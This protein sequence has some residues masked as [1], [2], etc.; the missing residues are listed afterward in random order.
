MAIKTKKSYLELI[1]SYHKNQE[2]FVFFVGSGLSQPL[3]PSWCKL[4]EELLEIAKESNP[5]YDE[6]ELKQYIK[7]GVHYLDIAEACVRVINPNKYRDLMEK[8]FDKEFTLDDISE[9][10]KA[11]MALSPKLI[12]T[13]NYDR[14]P[15]I[16]GKGRYRSCTNKN[17][18]EAMR[19]I[20]DGKNVVFKMHGD[21]TDQSSIVL[22][23]S[24]YQK[25][26]HNNPSTQ[27]LFKNLLSTKVL[28]FIGFSL[29]DPHIETIL[30]NIKSINKDIPLSHYVLLN[31]ESTFK[32]TTFENKY[33]V[34]IISY[35]PEN[36][37]HPE[38]ADLLR[39]LNHEIGEIPEATEKKIISEISDINILLKY[40]DKAISDTIVGS[41]VSIFYENNDIYLSFTP[42]GETMSEI[43][44]E[45]LSIIRL[46]NFECKLF[47][48]LIILAIAKTPPSIEVD[49]SQIVFLKAKMKYLDAKNY[50]EKQIST[51][52]MWKLIEFRFPASISNIFQNEQKMD[53]PLSTGIVGE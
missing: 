15:D 44:K 38:V 46:I 12:I 22:T 52:T 39:A 13:T 18:P 32:I 19:S 20:V 10:Y 51:S 21:I 45:I 9:G 31:E 41:G 23:A 11:L 43:H 33:G 3:F 8:I 48:N 28:I 53:F 4:L 50:A 1:E 34:K 16:A 37:K 17:A 30:E 29:S 2:K 36:D 27:S 25:I 40:L 49:K 26:I 6:S 42:M 7:D 47:N 35:T 5:S 24:D 14:I